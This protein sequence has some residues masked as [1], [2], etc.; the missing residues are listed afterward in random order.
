MRHGRVENARQARVPVSIIVLVVHVNRFV[1]RNYC[2]L[3]GGTLST[4]SRLSSQT[5][6]CAP[7]RPRNLLNFGRDTSILA[8]VQYLST[9]VR[10]HVST[11]P[12]STASRN[13][14]QFFANRHFGQSEHRRI[15]QCRWTQS[16]GKVWR[17]DSTDGNDGALA[18]SASGWIP[19]YLYYCIRLPCFLGF[20]APFLLIASNAAAS[21]PM[22]AER[23]R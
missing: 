14:C 3:V 10:V 20:G 9:T 4:Y 21:T 1:R 17:T 19:F 8:T 13:G 15:Q 23:T 16:V 7:G 18:N 5:K 12:K 2:D 22:L 6:T 11:V